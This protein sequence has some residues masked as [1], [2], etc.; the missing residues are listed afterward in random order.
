MPR[1]K[2]AEEET[3]ER[4]FVIRQARPVVGQERVGCDLD[5]D[6]DG[7]LDGAFEGQVIDVALRDVA[8]AEDEA[9][10]LHVEGGQGGLELARGDGLPLRGALAFLVEP[11]SET[12]FHGGGASG[13]LAFE[14][15]FGDADSLRMVGQPGF[16][17]GGRNVVRRFVGVVEQ[18]HD[19]VII[20]MQDRVVFVRMA[21]GAVERESHPGGAG[22]ADA[23]DHGVEA[24]FVRVGAAFLVE[25]RIT[26]EARGDEVVGRGAGE[27]VSG[28]LLDAELVV[29]QVGVEGLH[30]P[31]AVRPDGARAVF[32]ETVGVGVA[33]EVEPAT[34]PAFAVAR[35]GEQAIDELF[36]SI[37]GF[38]VNEGVGFL[39][40]RRHAGEV[41]GDAADEDVAVGLRRGLEA[42]LG[43]SGADEGVDGMDASLRQGHLLRRGESP[44]GLILAAFGDP[45]AE[46]G[47]LLLGHR[48]LGLRRGHELVLVV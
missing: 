4:A 14:R 39:R 37:G 26:M 43:E 24:V 23:V 18:R 11:F 44:V 32:L 31:V 5:A 10:G 35:R 22:D 7:A 33:G 3:A 12:F 40:R 47:L 48:L 2:F 17:V 21:L 27:E 29:G 28:E 15:I 34:G 13:E 46:Y 9:V 25:H 16:Q 30:D 45:G 19:G 20:R 6:G 38:V 1:L 41:E 8:A 36:V 42:F